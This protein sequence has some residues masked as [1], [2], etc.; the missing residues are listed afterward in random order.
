[1][2]LINKNP[3]RVLD[4]PLTASDRETAKQ[5]NSL[6][7][8]A[9]MGKA[10]SYNSDFPFLTPIERTPNLIVDVGINTTYT[11]PN[12]KTDSTYYFSVTCYDNM[13]NESWF[14]DLVK[15]DPTV[16]VNEKNSSSIT[17]F[18]LLQN[19]PNPFNPSTKI[20]YSIPQ[21]CFVTLKVYDVLGKEISTLVN[22]NKFSG[23]YQV[24]FKGTSFSS[25]IY[26]YRIQAGSFSATK[27]FI[28]LR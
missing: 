28:L 4:L 18:K 9:E 27:K 22:E 24:E 14:S 11:I 15:Y 17:S 1:M 2:N 10:K 26:F 6:L 21:T 8:Y 16:N 5:I 7:I 25:G 23:K 13:G 20:E 12:L 3:Y 19:Y